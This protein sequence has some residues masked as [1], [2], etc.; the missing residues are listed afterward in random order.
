[1]KRRMQKKILQNRQQLL[2]N[3]VSILDDIDPIGIISVAKESGFPVTREYLPEA[4]EI[5]TRLNTGTQ[6]TELELGIKHIFG[7]FFHNPNVPKVYYTAAAR[8]ILNAWYTFIDR[9][10]IKYTDKLK[11]PEHPTPIKIEID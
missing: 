2:D 9:P 7:Y 10:I 8:E 5:V 4:M 3:T 6:F 1:M 11:L